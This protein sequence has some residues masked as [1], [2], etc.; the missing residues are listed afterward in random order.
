MQQRRRAVEQDAGGLAVLV[1]DDLAALGRR[2]APRDARA[3]EGEPV[4]PPREGVEAR[5]ADGM[6][7]DLLAQELL[8]SG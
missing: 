2:R 4:P 8:R 6:V 7:R 3:L 1:L 5:E